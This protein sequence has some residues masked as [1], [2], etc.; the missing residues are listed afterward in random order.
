MILA[1]CGPDGCE[2]LPVPLRWALGAVM[3]ALALAYGWAWCV[4]R[5]RNRER[6]PDD[7]EG[8]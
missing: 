4:D 7:W 6:R 1:N 3:A 5:W 8:R 2:A